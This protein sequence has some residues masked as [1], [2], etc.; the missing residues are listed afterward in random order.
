MEKQKR[1]RKPIEDKKQ[2]LTIYQ[3]LSLIKKFGGKEEI[4]NKIN[5]FIKTLENETK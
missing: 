3:P 2:P 4:K 1:G 5:N